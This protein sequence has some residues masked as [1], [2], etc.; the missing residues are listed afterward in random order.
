MNRFRKVRGAVI[1]R[2]SQ[3]IT[4]HQ[5]G[6]IDHERICDTVEREGGNVAPGEYR[7]AIGKCPLLHRKML[8]LQRLPSEPAAG[9]GGCDLCHDERRHHERGHLSALHSIPCPMFQPGNGPFTLRQGGILVG[10]ACPPGF[11]VHSQA[12]FLLLYDRIKKALARGGEVRVE[13]REEMG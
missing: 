3:E 7:V 12:T 9:S 11:V 1:G 13:V 5:G 10:E 4:D 2:L 6:V 8:F